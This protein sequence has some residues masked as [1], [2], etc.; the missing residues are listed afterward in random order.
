MKRNLVL[1]LSDLYF[2]SP[3]DEVAFFAWLKGLACVDQVQ[4]HGPD[5]HVDITTARL[6]ETE[7]R[8][9]I[10]IL[11]RYHHPLHLLRPLVKKSFFRWLNDRKAFWYDDLFKY[12][13]EKSKP[14]K[15]GRKHIPSGTP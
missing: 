14:G 10:A 15:R 4:G 1:I 9:L 3:G 5:L 2:S 12:T 11:R 6:Q 8:E 7:M 13:R